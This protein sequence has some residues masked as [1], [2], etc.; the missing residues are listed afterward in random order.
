[1]NKEAYGKIKKNKK[2]FKKISFI[3]FPGSV[4]KRKVN[5]YDTEVI[6]TSLNLCYYIVNVKLFKYYYR[7]K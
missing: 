6:F 4:K 7:N 3:T 5:T 2:T 1:M